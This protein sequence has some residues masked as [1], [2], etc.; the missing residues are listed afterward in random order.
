MVVPSV[1]TRRDVGRKKKLAGAELSSIKLINKIHTPRY[2]RSHGARLIH[3]DFEQIVIDTI[4]NLFIKRLGCRNNKIT[5]KRKS[6]HVWLVP[7][8]M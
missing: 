2:C 6:V 5:K 4:N 8:S 1:T 7:V 3:G